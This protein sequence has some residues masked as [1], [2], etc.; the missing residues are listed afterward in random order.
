MQMGF[1]V[2]WCTVEILTDSYFFMMVGDAMLT[3]QTWPSY[4]QSKTISEPTLNFFV[5]KESFL[6]IKYQVISKLL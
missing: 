4:L 2:K 1:D 5:C 3:K 6:Y